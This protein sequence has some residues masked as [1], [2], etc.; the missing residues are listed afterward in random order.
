MADG[1]IFSPN[2]LLEKSLLIAW[3]RNNEVQFAGEIQSRGCCY[4]LQV[5]SGDKKVDSTDRLLYYSST[6]TCYK[7][8]I[9][10]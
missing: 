6:C 1:H 3:L 8:N 4:Q 2:P 9:R 7:K 10:L 5:P